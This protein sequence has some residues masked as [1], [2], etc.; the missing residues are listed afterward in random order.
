MLLR[1]KSNRAVL[2]A[3]A[4]ATLPLLI[5]CI[6]ALIFINDEYWTIVNLFAIVSPSTV[7]SQFVLFFCSI[8]LLRL[9][10]QIYTKFFVYLE[11]AEGS[12][13]QRNRHVNQDSRNNES[14]IGTQKPMSVVSTENSA[15]HTKLE[16]LMYIFRNLSQICFNG[17]LH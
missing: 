12:S 1:V 3:L 16:F 7:I 15:M 6:I 5:S 10:R 11:I 9:L 13:Q 8:F 17:C 2:T 4:I 14:V